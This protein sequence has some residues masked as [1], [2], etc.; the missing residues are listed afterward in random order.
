MFKKEASQH[1][2]IDID[3]PTSRR[4]GLADCWH[5]LATGEARRYARRYRSLDYADLLAEAETALL[6]ACDEVVPAPTYIIRTFIKRRIRQAL[7]VLVRRERR[8]YAGNLDSTE[9]LPDDGPEP[10]DTLEETENMNYILANSLSPSEEQCWR[11]VEVEGLTQIDAAEQ[12]CVSQ[13]RVSQML[14]TA[15]DK[16]RQHFGNK[17]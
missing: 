1:W 12:L 13:P 5:T 11:L 8:A 2:G 4:D 7:D 16:L 15:R 6:L 9:W 17:V 10:G 3:S 14:N